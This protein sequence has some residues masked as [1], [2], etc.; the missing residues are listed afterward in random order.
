MFYWGIAFVLYSLVMTIHGLITK[1]LMDYGIMG[2]VICIA[3]FVAGLVLMIKGVKPIIKN[4]KTA[5]YGKETYGRVLELYQGKRKEDGRNF[6]FAKFVMIEDGQV[7]VKSEVVGIAINQEEGVRREKIGISLRGCGKGDY[8]KLKY[9][10]D[11][12]NFV[13]N[14]KEKDI[15]QDVVIIINEKIKEIYEEQRV[16]YEIDKSTKPMLNG[17][18]YKC[19]NE[20]HL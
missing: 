1:T 19:E 20:E 16:Q 9:F 6:T 8:V 4:I 5:K 3:F 2:V 17:E 14:V 10:E 18:V 7:V 12:I 15:P 13:A 11:D